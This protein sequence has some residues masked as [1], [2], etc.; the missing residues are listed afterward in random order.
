MIKNIYFKF[1]SSRK[2]VLAKSPENYGE[3][4]GQRREDEAVG[5]GDDESV[6]QEELDQAL[7]DLRH[8]VLDGGR[9]ITAQFLLRHT[10]LDCRET[11]MSV[12]II[13]FI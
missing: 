8:W 4:V 7:A 11:Q 12:I 1:F 6:D 2:A 5:S 3:K 13:Y 10:P 9:P